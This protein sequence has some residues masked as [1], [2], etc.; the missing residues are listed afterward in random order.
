MNG[1]IRGFR[2]SPMDRRLSTCCLLKQI[3]P[4]TAMF[5]HILTSEQE[6]MEYNVAARWQCKTQWV[7]NSTNTL[8]II[9]KTKFP[10]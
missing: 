6:S 8:E 1:I 4:H 3:P 7:R 5:V 10:C 2:T 9:L